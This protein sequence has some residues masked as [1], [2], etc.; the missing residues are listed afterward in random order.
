MLRLSVENV[1]GLNLLNLD[2][3]DGVVVGGGVVVALSLNLV[4][5]NLVLVLVRAGEEVVSSLVDVFLDLNL[6]RDLVSEETWRRN[7]CLGTSEPGTRL[8]SFLT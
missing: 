8:L 1:L 4:S 6:E 3:A 5:L 2:T 7:C